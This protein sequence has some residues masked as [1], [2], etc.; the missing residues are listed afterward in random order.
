MARAYF[1]YG[2]PGESDQT[3]DESLALIRNGFVPCRPYF[4]ILDLFPGTALYEDFKRRTGTT[5]D[6]W[7]ERVEDM[8]YFRNG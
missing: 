5:D 4:Y 7:L 8:L 6:I 2:A 1:I 3:I